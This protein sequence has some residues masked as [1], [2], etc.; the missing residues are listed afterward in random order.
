[1]ISG[2][3]TSFD[4]ETQT[5][6]KRLAEHAAGIDS[7][8][9][10][11]LFEGAQRLVSRARVAQSGT[12][13]LPFPLVEVAQ[14]IAGDAGDLHDGRNQIGRC[15]LHA[16]E[17]VEP[18]RGVVRRHDAAERAIE[19]R[20]RA[21]A[22]DGPEQARVGRGAANASHELVADLDARR[23]IEPFQAGGE[24]PTLALFLRTQPRRLLAAEPES[25]DD[26]LRQ[27]PLL[28]RRESAGHA[29]PENEPLDT[30]LYRARKRQARDIDRARFTDAPRILRRT[31]SRPQT[32]SEQV[33]P[34]RLERRGL[35]A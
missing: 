1:M 31:E 25:A 30:I 4:G 28:A 32:E 11:R 8:S 23:D 2:V 19:R 27:L 22:A 14:R 24:T 17:N 34:P 13:A 15:D 12:G 5:R 6:G 20:A 33:Q 21:D 16:D 3:F 9:H 26:T 10:D 29:I 18:P 7:R 35:A